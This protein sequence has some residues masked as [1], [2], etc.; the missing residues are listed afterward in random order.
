L[1]R[2][3]RKARCRTTGLSTLE[4]VRRRAFLNG[5]LRPL[6]LNTTRAPLGAL[7]ATSFCSRVKAGPNAHWFATTAPRS[8]NGSARLSQ[9]SSTLLPRRSCAVRFVAALVLVQCG[10]AR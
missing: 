4:T 7:C 8:A 9:F 3:R 1:R 2:D 6:Q 5:Q 10:G